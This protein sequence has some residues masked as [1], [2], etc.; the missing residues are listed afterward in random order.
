MSTTDPGL[1]SGLV[2]CLETAIE[3]GSIA[4]F[5]NGDR[6]QGAVGSDEMSRAEGLLPSIDKLIADSGYRRSQ[7][8]AVVVS[9]GP[10]S[11]TSI[12]IGLATAM[13]L[14]AALD[15]P[16]IG[17]TAFEAL[18]N[19]AGSDTV[20]VAIPM[21]RDL[22]A[23]QSFRSSISVKEPELISSLTF[24]EMIDRSAVGNLL[25]HHSLAQGLSAHE[26]GIVDVGS[27]IASML[28]SAAPRYGRVGELHPLF[29]D[30]RQ[31]TKI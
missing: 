9:T 24:H 15:I 2:L 27:D 14:S 29:L 25:A 3:G 19:S 22:V 30:R 17:I 10:G 12:R 16:C 7:L 20:T 26:S 31:F 21:G 28:Y 18:A 11:F 4:I 13:G 1:L 23:I 6:V 5:H 8:D